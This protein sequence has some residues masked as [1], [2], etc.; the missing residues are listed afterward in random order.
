MDLDPGCLWAIATAT[1]AASPSAPGLVVISDSLR[2]LKRAEIPHRNFKR[3][4]AAAAA[5]ATILSGPGSFPVSGRFPSSPVGRLRGA[6]E[7]GEMTRT[8]HVRV[9]ANQ[10]AG[11]ITVIYC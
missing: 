7:I 6:R 2:S 3:F 1:A 5:A 9:R 11:S 8:R 10:D 4:R